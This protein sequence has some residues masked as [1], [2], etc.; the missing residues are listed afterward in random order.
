MNGGKLYDLKTVLGHSDMKTTERY[1]H[2]SNEHL[3]G[4]KDII[5]P[6]IENSADVI[7]VF[8]SITQD[9]SRSIHAPIENAKVSNF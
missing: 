1:A 2:L 9:R 8:K 5:K 4:V 7:D 6:K 3:A